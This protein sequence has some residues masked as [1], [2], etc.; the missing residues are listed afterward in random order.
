LGWETLLFYGL[1]ELAALTLI[2]ALLDAANQSTALSARR[3][4]FRDK[5][6]SR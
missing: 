4:T 2:L 3:K 1:I 6:Y 5:T